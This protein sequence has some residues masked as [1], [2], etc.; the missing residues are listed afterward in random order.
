MTSSDLAGCPI[1]DDSNIDELCQ[2]DESKS[3]FGR[4]RMPR[5]WLENP[6]GSMPYCGAP[7]PPPIPR[8]EWKERILD[9]ERQGAVISKVAL[10]AGVRTKN[11]KQTNFCWCFAPTLAL[12][13]CRVLAGERYISLSPASVACMITSYRNVGGW[14]QNA[15]KFMGESGIV[16]SALWDDTAIDRKLDN[17]KSREDRPFNIVQEWADL[18]RR[19]DDYFMTQL[20]LGRPVC[21]GLDFWGHEILAMDPLVFEDGG[22]GY[23]FWNTWGEG[24]GQGGFGVFRLGSRGSPDDAQ[25]PT[26]VRPARHNSKAKSQSLVL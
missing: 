12:E 17:L 13:I 4:G 2:L 26:V 7:L 23:R 3:Q 9:R 15:I 8:S 24:W 25:V 16:S 20:I 6:R 22:F 1:I 21:V 10:A 19:N 14:T 18:P 5:D 11:Q